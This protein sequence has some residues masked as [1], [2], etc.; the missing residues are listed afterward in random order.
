ML[1]SAIAHHR[2]CASGL[3]RAYEDGAGLPLEFI[4]GDKHIPGIDYSAKDSGSI[5]TFRCDNENRGE[6]VMSVEV[7]LMIVLG[8]LAPWTEVDKLMKRRPQPSSAAHEAAT[9]GERN[10]ALPSQ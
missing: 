4:C 9:S 3:Y 7:T 6:P 8:A 2:A 1:S 10:K 5:P